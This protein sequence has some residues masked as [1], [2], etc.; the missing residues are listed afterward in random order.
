MILKIT[1]N[2][3]VIIDEKF[4]YLS[5]YKWHLSAKRYASRRD[6][7]TGKMV[8]MHREIMKA[9]DNE[10]VDHINGNGLDNRIKNLR[11]CTH[12]ENIRNKKMP[13]HNTSG[14]KGVTWDK[15]M[16]KWRV[17]VKHSKTNSY[18]GLF[19]NIIEASNAYDK[20]AREV[21]GEFARC[22]N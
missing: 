17:Q 22:N 14:Y 1:Q 8:S 2:K 10:C 19:N 7:K 18:V 13:S 21:F 15:Q 5:G 20:R 9:K 3:Q 4:E 16:K 11:L 6:K 12:Q